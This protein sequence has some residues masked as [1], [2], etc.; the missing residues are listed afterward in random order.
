MEIIGILFNLIVYNPMLNALLWLYSIIPNYGIVI[1]IFTILIGT[2]TAPFR[3][4][5][6]QSM[7][8]Q[9]EKM[10][11]LKPKLDEIKKKYKDNPQQL[12][13]AQMKLYQEHGVANPFN[14]GCLF[15]LLSFPIFIGLYQVINGVMADRP[16]Q[17]MALSQHI[18]P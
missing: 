12:Q 3:I 5:S 4:K 13:A 2:A 18:Y 11:A 1:I 17:L 14:A 16:E 7:K 6:Q 15:I 9:Q 8:K 10:A